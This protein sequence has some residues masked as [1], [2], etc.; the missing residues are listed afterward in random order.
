MLSFSWADCEAVRTQTSVSLW[1]ESKWNATSEV[2]WYAVVASKVR[3]C[4]PTISGI[5]AK[6]NTI[7]ILCGT[8]HH[9]VQWP[10]LPWGQSSQPFSSGAASPLQF[11]LSSVPRH[12]CVPCVPYCQAKQGWREKLV[13]FQPSLFVNLVWDC[14]LKTGIKM[15]R[16][17]AGTCTGQVYMPCLLLNGRNGYNCRAS[18][19]AQK[20]L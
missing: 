10:K 7:R 1:K 5:A 9:K 4:K 11:D 13:A 18:T 14:D 19:P 16:S 6:G 2:S 12:Q 3:R 17:Q 15:A 8:L 20:A